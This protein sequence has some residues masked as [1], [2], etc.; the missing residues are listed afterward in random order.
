MRL[1]DAIELE[2]RMCELCNEN[3]S[4]E[5]CEP[6]DCIFCNAVRNS[7]TLTPPN[8]WI[9]VEERLPEPLVDVL[10]YSREYGIRLNY[11]DDG[12]FVYEDEY[13]QQRTFGKSTHWMPLPE[14]PEEETDD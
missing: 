5:P 9:R 10:T 8:K 11:V 1:I 3:Y 2:Q 13:P 6:S 12:S 4:N 7:P 14:P